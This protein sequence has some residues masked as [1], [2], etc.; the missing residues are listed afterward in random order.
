[1]MQY[2]LPSAWTGV[3]TTDLSRRTAVMASNRGVWMWTPFL[4]VKFITFMKVDSY[5]IISSIPRPGESLLPHAGATLKNHFFSLSYPP[6]PIS[7]R[8]LDEWSNPRRVDWQVTARRA[9][10][11]SLI[12]PRLGRGG[13]EGPPDPNCLRHKISWA[14]DVPRIFTKYFFP[15]NFFSQN[16]FFHKIFFG[17]IIWIFG[18]AYQVWSK[19]CLRPVKKLTQKVEC[20]EVPKNGSTTCT[21]NP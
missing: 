21:I 2:F 19:A 3:C 9:R 14:N 13:R 7:R 6:T 11:G 1:M 12:L 18:L 15:K 4:S 16:F 17:R 20:T 10:A 5:I 8:I